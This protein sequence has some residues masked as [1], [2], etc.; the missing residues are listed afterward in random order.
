MIH[1]E[2]IRQDTQAYRRGV[3]LG[4]TMAEIFLL[5]LFCLLIAAAVLFQQAAKSGDTLSEVAEEQRQEIE[6]LRETLEQVSQLQQTQQAEPGAPTPEETWRKL[7]DDQLVLNRAREAGLDVEAMTA[8]AG[9]YQ[10]IAPLIKAGVSGQQLADNYQYSEDLARA[11]SEVSLSVKSPEEIAR[12]ARTGSSI[13][14]DGEHDWPPI[15]NLSEAAGY[16]FETGKAALSNEF[17][18]ALSGPIIEQVADIVARY[19]ANIVEVVGHTDERNLPGRASNLDRSLFPA[20]REELPIDALSPSDN[21]GLG[22]ARAVSV[23][24]L[25]RQDSRLQNVTVLPLSG[26]QLIRPGDSITD[27]ASS[28]DEAGRRRIEI[29]V[30][31]PG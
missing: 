25:L 23:A 31:R 1:T 14:G 8:V 29:R 2:S 10:A 13:D 15:I 16:S 26:G 30:R 7:V 20:L 21:T 4:M 11:L 6:A 22:M 17:R 18:D 27:G 5:L 9:E 28:G 3:V 19:D 24:R 12:L